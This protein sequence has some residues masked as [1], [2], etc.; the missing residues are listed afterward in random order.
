MHLGW[1]K[2]GGILTDTHCTSAINSDLFHVKKFSDIGP[3]FTVTKCVLQ[4]ELF[5][6]EVDY[7][8]CKCSTEQGFDII[9]PDQASY[10]SSFTQMGAN[11]DIT[12][13]LLDYP[14]MNDPAQCKY[15]PRLSLPQQGRA[16]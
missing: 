16:K 10:N 3:N 2:T 7:N 4:F 11:S 13:D 5:H 14:I 12:M 1:L 6:S 8:V 9:P 15:L